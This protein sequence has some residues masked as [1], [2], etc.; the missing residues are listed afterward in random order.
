MLRYDILRSSGF[1]I[2]NSDNAA[3]QWETEDYLSQF[4]LPIS[5][6]SSLSIPQTTFGVAFNH[7]KLEY[8]LFYHIVKR[9]RKKTKNGLPRQSKHSYR[10]FCLRRPAYAAGPHQDGKESTKHFCEAEHR[11]MELIFLDQMCLQQEKSGAGQY[12]MEKKRKD[13]N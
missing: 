7:H 8:I 5:S 13:C 3:L 1:S 2:M 12:F 4:P 11:C 10:G 6:L 9:E